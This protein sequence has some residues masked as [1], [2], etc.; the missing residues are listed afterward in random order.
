MVITFNYITHKV[1]FRVWIKAFI[2]LN[3][4]IFNN[5]DHTC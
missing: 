4:N 2:F 3:E 5:N 1:H